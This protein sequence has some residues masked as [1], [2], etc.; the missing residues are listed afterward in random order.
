MKIDLDVKLKTPKGEEFE[1][2]ASLGTALYAVLSAQL[3]TDAQIPANKRLD[4][5]RLLQRIAA[6]GE[7]EITVDEAAD[8]KERANKLL[9][10]PAFGA[11][12]E[13]LESAR[14]ATL[15]QAVKTA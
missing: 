15:P 9:P 14:V 5:Y 4:A 3:P 11:I 8:I 2:K 6:G 12:M 1:D 13:Q 7:L 10:L